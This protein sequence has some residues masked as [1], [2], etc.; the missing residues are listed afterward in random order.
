MFFSKLD[1]VDDP[2]AHSRALYVSMTLAGLLLMLP[3]LSMAERLPFLVGDVSKREL[4]EQYPV[5]QES[6]ANHTVG[7]ALVDLPSDLAVT[8][9]FGTWCHDS[10]REVPRLL[11]LLTASGV[12]DTA[13]NLIGLDIRKQEPLGRGEA[14]GARYT[15]TFIFYSDGHEIGRIVERPDVSF[16]NDLSRFL[17][18]QP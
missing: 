16:A 11:K 12:A 1:Q 3:T 14:L 5:F 10:E 2:Y 9:L 17:G 7:Q 8:I 4:L 15:P 6:Y 18:P 13:I